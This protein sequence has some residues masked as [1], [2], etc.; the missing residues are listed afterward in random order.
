MLNQIKINIF[1]NMIIVF[2]IS[3]EYILFLILEYSFLKF[4]ELQMIAIFLYSVLSTYK[5]TKNWLDLYI[6]FLALTFLFMLSRP[7]LHLF[8]LVDFIN[9][10]EQ[11][12]FKNS[13]NFYFSDFTMIKINFILIYSLLFLNIGYLIGYKKYFRNS[14]YKTL[15]DGFSKI[16]NKKIAYLFFILGAGA[17]LIKVMLYVKLL[18]Q[19]GY[20][21]LYSGNYTLPILV[22]IFDDFLYIR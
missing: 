11:Q 10:N 2:I 3:V 1:I 15:K 4:I 19:Y 12:W 21:Y 6:I 22:R 16:F 5:I 14:S 18:N 8:D 17:F 9:Y 7:F 13:D 20:F